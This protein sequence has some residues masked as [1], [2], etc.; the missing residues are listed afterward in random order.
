M[1]RL[2]KLLALAVVTCTA[3]AAAPAAHAAEVW[4]VHRLGTQGVDEATA[5]TFRDLLIAELGE[6]VAATFAQADAVCDGSECA[7]V[8]AEQLGADVAVFGTVS[9][10]G[11]KILVNLYVVDAHDGS[12]LSR[13]KMDVDRVE[14]L[15]TVALRVAKAIAGGR[16]VS[17]TAELGAITHREVQPDLRREG[18]RGLGLYLG[19][20]VPVSEA[21]QGGGPGVLIDGSYWFETTDF[22]IEP[23]I[24]LRFNTNGLDDASDWIEIPV[25]VGVY[26]ILGRGDLAPFFGGG[27]GLRFAW[28]DESRTLTQGDVIKTTHTAEIEDGGV[29]FGVFGRAGLM[30]LRTYAMRMSISVEYNA[31]LRDFLDRGVPQQLNFALGVYF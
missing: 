12:T 16:H 11:R 8:T 15:D 31:I 26:Y 25:D 13:H 4:V 14:D 27:A 9:A 10:L 5:A 2:W 23:R 3:L 21:F 29:G 30:L 18:A 20:V 6:R 1:N 24:G 28:A 7:R 17:E 22:A 19:G